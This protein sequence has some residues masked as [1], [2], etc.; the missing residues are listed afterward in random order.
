MTYPHHY[1]ARIPDLVPNSTVILTDKTDMTFSLPTGN[2]LLVI[3]YQAG[4]VPVAAVYKNLPSSFINS[5]SEH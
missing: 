2:H 5:L 4:L 1:A 3:D